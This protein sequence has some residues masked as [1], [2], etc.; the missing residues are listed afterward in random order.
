[1]SSL[2]SQLHS[3]CVQN[4]EERINTIQT[5]IH[6]AQASADEET[7]SSAGDKYETGR[8][9]MQLEIENNNTQLAE[10]NKLKSTLD[11]INPDITSKIIQQGSLVITNQGSFY[12]SVGIGP[13][14][15]NNQTYFAISSA[16]PIG[17]L[18]M[19]KSVNEKFL[20]KNREYKIEKIE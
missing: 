4:I 2:K 10:A 8:A 9:M 13:I 7:K 12:L 11:Q 17:A 19:N 1:M 16:S 14:K 18:L 6:T 3:L 15:L 20:F 5:A